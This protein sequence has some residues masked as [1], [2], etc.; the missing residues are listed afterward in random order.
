MEGGGLLQTSNDVTLS[1]SH[2]IFPEMTVP[3]GNTELELPLEL[4]KHC[5]P[6]TAIL[7]PARR[8]MERC[9]ILISHSLTRTGPNQEKTMVRILNCSSAPVIIYQI[10]EAGVLSPLE[11]PGEICTITSS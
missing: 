10:E 5:Y 3:P 11:E 1:V 7:E 2:V 6:G 4:S 8:F 9:G